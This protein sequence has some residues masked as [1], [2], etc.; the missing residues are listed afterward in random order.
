M[1]GRTLLSALLTVSLVITPAAS[2][3]AAPTKQ[4]VA[5]AQEAMK[6]GAAAEK[7][8]DWSA[9][10]D[11][12]QSAVDKN[13]TPDARLHLA[14][15]ESH[16]G[17]LTEATDQYNVIL[18]TKTAPA[19]IKA[20]AKKELAAIK[21]R[22]PKI[23]VKVPAGFSGTVRIDKVELTS[24]NFGQPVEINP[25]TR[26][27]IVESEG[28]QP[29]KKTLIIADRANEVVDVT[30]VP[31]KK[32]AAG[33]EV[34]VDTNDG[35]TRR[36]LGYVALGLG[37]AGLITGIA[38]GA[39]SMSTRNQLKSSCNNNVC[40]ESERDSYDRGKMQATISTV[41]WIVAGVGV[42]A[43]L[44]LILTAPSKKKEA[45]PKAEEEKAAVVPYIGPGSLGLYGRF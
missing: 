41:G 14:R 11:A 24:A 22:I 6:E 1:L 17:H 7:K 28:F 45:A 37:G 15:A 9:A 31:V 2:V 16:L 10:R 29:F 27:V 39:A 21:D 32:E 43:G 23:T 44:V 33:D 5:A 38:A 20:A 25:G 30:L 19:P 42:G 18:E 36:T 3:W 35:S 26:N 4:D 12:Y 34:K 13:E 40:A 8:S